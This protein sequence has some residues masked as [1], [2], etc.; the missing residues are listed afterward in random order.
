[1]GGTCSTGPRSACWW[2]EDW[3]VRHLAVGRG[4][5]HLTAAGGWSVTDS[6]AVA[7]SSAETA[8]RTTTR[9]RVP[10]NWPR[11]QV[12]PHRW[13]DQSGDRSANCSILLY[14][15]WLFTTEYLG[16]KQPTSP[17]SPPPQSFV[18]DEEASLRGRWDRASLLL[19]Q[20]STKRCPQCSVPVERNGEKQS[21]RVWTSLNQSERVWTSLNGSE[22]ST[23]VWQYNNSLYESNLVTHNIHSIR[24]QWGK[25]VSLTFPEQRVSFNIQNLDVFRDC[26]ISV[27][28]N[29]LSEVQLVLPAVS[30]RS[31]ERR[32]PASKELNQRG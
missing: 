5:S 15:M 19:L 14:V 9:G 1:M 23:G 20:E 22:R 12:E 26:R 4:L 2:M 8:G 28:V 27:G 10:R 18:V 21:E 6:S 25:N 7:S 32:R 29:E 11:P 17:P 31:L 24:G 16:P 3:C 13:A 30:C